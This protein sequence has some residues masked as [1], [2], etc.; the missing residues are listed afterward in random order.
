MGRISRPDP[1]DS[2][3]RRHVWPSRKRN[4]GRKAVCELLSGEKRAPAYWLAGDLWCDAVEELQWVHRIHPEWMAD[5]DD[6]G[7]TI[8]WDVK[9]SV[10]GPRTW[11]EPPEA[12]E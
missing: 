5:D 8:Y 11:T 3:L 1:N 7:L 4:A 6:Y 9:D 12:H 10:A 2:G